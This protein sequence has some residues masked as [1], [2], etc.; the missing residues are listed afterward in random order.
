MLQQDLSAQPSHHVLGVHEHKPH[1]LS[2]LLLYRHKQS[3]IDISVHYTNNHSVFWC[4][5]LI[6]ILDYQL[7]PS[8]VVSFALLLSSE[9]YL[10][11]LEVSLVLDSFNKPHPAEQSSDTAACH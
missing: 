7:F 10:V 6:F 2:Y 5:V 1:K 11:S 9:R 3:D 8:I 4:A